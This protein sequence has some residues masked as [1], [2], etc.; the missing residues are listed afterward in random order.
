MRAALGSLAFFVV[1]PGTIAGLGPWLVTRWHMGPAFF[2]FH[3]LRVIGA[4]FIAGGLLP[5]AASFARFVFE[6][7]GTPAPNAPPMR[8]VTGGYYRQSRNP[9][10]AGI[11]M[12]LLGQALLFANAAM[13]AYAAV[14]WLAFHLR[15]VLYEEPTLRRMFGAEYEAYCARVPRWVRVVFGSD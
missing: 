15:V 13:F 12:M 3:S 14:A 10:Y 9:M 6:G 11:V 7:S 4:V 1:A 2:G 8:L 5:L